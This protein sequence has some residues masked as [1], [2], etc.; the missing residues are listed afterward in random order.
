MT[1]KDISDEIEEELEIHVE[2]TAIRN[3]IT[4]FSFNRNFVR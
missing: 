3:K 1:T 2:D 4:F